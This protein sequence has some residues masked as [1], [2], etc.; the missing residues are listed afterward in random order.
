MVLAAKIVRRPSLS[1]RRRGE[2]T[3]K[4]LASVGRE[5]AQAAQGSWSKVELLLTER[6]KG[7]EAAL[8]LKVPL[9][10]AAVGKSVHGSRR[11]AD[12]ATWTSL[13]KSAKKR[14]WRT[15]L[16]AWWS[17][18]ATSSS[19]SLVCAQ[20]PHSR[21]RAA[22]PNLETRRALHDLRIHTSHE[23]ITTHGTCTLII[24]SIFNSLVPSQRISCFVNPK[25][26]LNSPT[27]LI[28]QFVIS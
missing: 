7:L 6:I 21:C 18:E 14:R 28:V 19:R 11:V 27:L 2:S 17:E 25:H 1:T 16:F 15:R 24:A 13:A 23:T 9:G 8:L 3:R 12:G 26:Y 5:G 4:C 20:L 10:K 22:R